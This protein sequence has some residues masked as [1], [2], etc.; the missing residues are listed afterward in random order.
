MKPALAIV[1][2]LL[3][4]GCWLPDIRL[5]RSVT[6][7][8]IV[9]VWTM[10]EDSFQD[11]KTDSDASRIDGSHKDY[12]I[13]IRKDGTLRYRSLLQIPT[14]AVDY[15][16]TWQLKPRTDPPRGNR[17]DILLDANGDYGLSLDFTEEDG[18]LIIW[19]FFGDPDSWRLEKYK[20]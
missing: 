16:G 14:R 20:K 7:E 13:E 4:A 9:G 5:K 6:P 19:T 1:I 8:E 15:Q 18:M 11:I 2:T 10:T 12:Q 3:L 17:L